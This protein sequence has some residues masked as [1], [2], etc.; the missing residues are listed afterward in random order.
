MGF[1]SSTSFDKQIAKINHI[2][3]N[4]HGQRKKERKKEI[5]TKI[6]KRIQNLPAKQASWQADEAISMITYF[7]TR[8]RTH[9]LNGHSEEESEILSSSPFLPFHLVVYFAT[10][11]LLCFLFFSLTLS[12][13][14]EACLLG[15]G[16]EYFVQIYSGRRKHAQRKQ[17]EKSRVYFVIFTVS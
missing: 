17:E 4:L 8:V 16:T 1:T 2:N 15:L 5:C 11:E 10:Y 12:L 6:F 14:L 3:T 9:V 13:S 7:C